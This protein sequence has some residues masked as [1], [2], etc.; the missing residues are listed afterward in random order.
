MSAMLTFG[1]QCTPPSDFWNKGFRSGA[2]SVVKCISRKA[3]FHALPILSSVTAWAILILLT[4][5]VWDLRLGRWKSAGIWTAKIAG[6][7][8][9]IATILTPLWAVDNALGKDPLRVGSQ[10]AVTVSSETALLITCG[11]IFSIVFAKSAQHARPTASPTFIQSLEGLV[12]PDF[13]EKPSPEFY[14][15]EHSP[16]R[17]ASNSDHPA[18]SMTSIPA[19]Y[20]FEIDPLQIAMP[21]SKYSAGRAHKAQAA[22]VMGEEREKL[23]LPGVVNEGEIIVTQGYEVKSE[24]VRSRG[25]LWTSRSLFSSANI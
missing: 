7:G 25:K 23:G 3:I 19:D 14:E 18:P 8:A 22:R 17:P 4:L 10:I 13:K 9:C 6:L 24:A 11:S 12:D 21:K 20:P 5:A 15:N 1:F 2:N 16:P